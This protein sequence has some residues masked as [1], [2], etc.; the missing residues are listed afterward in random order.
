MCMYAYVCVY[1]CSIGNCRNENLVCGQHNIIFAN[2]PNIIGMLN[3]GM[4]NIG[5]L[6]LINFV[7]LLATTSESVG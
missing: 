7:L 6:L 5:M 3:I 1:V 4:L 2:M